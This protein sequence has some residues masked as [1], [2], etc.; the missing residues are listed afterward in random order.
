ML[1]VCTMQ[2]WH[3]MKHTVAVE[4]T[5]LFGAKGRKSWSGILLYGPPGTW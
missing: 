5:T 3:Y 4:V 2:K 1:L